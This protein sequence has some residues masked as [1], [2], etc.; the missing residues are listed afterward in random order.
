MIQR[1]QNRLSNTSRVMREI[2][3]AKEISRVL[4]ARNLGLDKST[5]SSIV[6]DLLG[7]GLIQQ[8]AE[9]ASGPQGGRKPVFLTL[10]RSYGCV[11][12]VEFRPESYNAVAVDLEGNIL[13]SK[14]EMTRLSGAN[15]TEGMLEVLGRLQEELRRTG[16]PLL[17]IGVGLSGVVNPRK[18]I[19]RY[20]I[21]LQ[22]EQPYDFGLEVAARVPVPTWLEN[23]ANACAWGELAF[24]RAR[25]LQ[26]FLFLLV[27]FRGI[28]DRSRF[29]EKTA[30]GIGIVINGRVYHG[31]D[32]SAGEFRSVLCTADS[33]G[34]FSLGEEEAFRVEEDPAVLQR[35]IH[36]LSANVAML[37]N[38]FNLGSIFLGGDIERYKK[39]VQ[40]ELGEAIQK[41]WPYPGGVNC[42]IQF[43]SLGEKAVAYGAA[44]MVLHRLFSET[45]DP[46]T[47]E[48]L[49][50]SSEKKSLV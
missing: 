34:Q 8:S 4:I 29:H 5:V 48:R 43:S 13:Y 14:F 22:I 40:A 27:E 17:G 12:G 9:G 36:E 1:K 16:V 30:V 41:N 37:V 7:I 46:Q 6:A 47:V 28:T 50:R 26:D 11:L 18:N 2:W 31:H 15:L 35:F 24:H 10:N 44:G 25:R 42:R 45:H 38:T 23:D 20:S 39:E 3:T 32:Y 49:F 19:L 33:R 21:P